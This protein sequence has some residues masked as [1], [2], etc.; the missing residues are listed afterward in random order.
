MVTGVFDHAVYALLALCSPADTDRKHLPHAGVL[1]QVLDGSLG[2]GPLRHNVTWHT[3]GIVPW[4]PPTKLSVEQPW[5][6]F[7]L[8]ELCICCNGHLA[9]CRFLNQR[10]PAAW[11]QLARHPFRAHSQRSRLLGSLYFILRSSN[12]TGTQ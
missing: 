2:C 3:C 12:P 4:T 11:Q 10:S 6:W 5:F 7:A 1:A 9:S 8:I